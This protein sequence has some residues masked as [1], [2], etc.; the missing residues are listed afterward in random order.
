MVTKAP[1]TITVPESN[2]LLDELEKTLGTNN[3]RFLGQRNK[4]IGL[5]MLD[6]GLRVGEVVQLQIS[7]LYKYSEP[8]KAL[9]IRV[10]I[11]KSK[12]ERIVPLST[13][14]QFEIKG[15]AMTWWKH[16]GEPYDSYAFYNDRPSQHIST[17]QVE[18]IINKAGDIVCKRKVTPHTLR[19]TFASRLMR[20]C[21]VQ[22][23][24]TL[25]GHQHITT[26]QIYQHPNHDDLTKAINDIEN[27]PERR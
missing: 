5:L 6:A 11:S 9:V 16:P 2:E 20:T 4:T 15:M 18:R 27:A 10:E 13:R 25:L 7:D 19:H 24:Q 3:E 14:L 21:N 22:I 8:V 23:V 17:R 26:T 12:L 1:V